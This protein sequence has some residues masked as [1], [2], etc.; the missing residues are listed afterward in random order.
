MKIQSR[1]DCWQ[2]LVTQICREYAQLNQDEKSWI[3]RHCQLMGVLQQKLDRVFL[4][5]QG[6]DLCRNCQGECCARGHNHMSLANLLALLCVDQQ[7]PL[8]DFSQTCPLLTPKGCQLPAAYRPY[9][10]ISF[11][12]ERIEPQ[13]N[14]QQL[15]EFYQT[16]KELRQLYRLFL[17]RYA[18][19][20]MSGLLIA[21]ARLQGRPFLQRTPASLI[22]E[23]GATYATSF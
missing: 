4:Q 22:A 12:C 10:C 7:L 13:L 1:Q 5:A 18:G 16:E 19:A 14:P 2:Q 9:N 23:P 20:S 11:V 15:A 3:I 17:E 6:E 8:L 21:A